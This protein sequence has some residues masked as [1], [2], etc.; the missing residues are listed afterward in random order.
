MGAL[1]GLAL[2][3]YGYIII[4]HQ[5]QC[6]AEQTNISTHTRSHEFTHARTHARTHAQTTTHMHTF[7]ITYLMLCDFCYFKGFLH[8]Y[9]F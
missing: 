6:F 7:N 8:Q 4:C 2:K 1:G 9:L 5:M 3:Q